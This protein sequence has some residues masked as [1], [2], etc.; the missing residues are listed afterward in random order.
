MNQIKNYL[1]PNS[2]L[3]CV[4]F[5][6][7]YS[8]ETV[9]STMI[10]INKTGFYPAEMNRIKTYMWITLSSFLVCVGFFIYNPRKTVSSTMLCITKTGFYPSDINRIETVPVDFTAFWYVLDLLFIIRGKL[11]IVRCFA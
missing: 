8:L 6:I 9:Y 1:F 10:S 5:F 11:S 7:Y 4:G 3:V 2:F